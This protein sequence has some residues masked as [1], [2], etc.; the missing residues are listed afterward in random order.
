ML[1]KIYIIVEKDF[2]GHRVVQ[3]YEQ[4][5]SSVSDGDLVYEVR[6]A[7]KVVKQEVKLQEISQ[8]DLN[9]EDHNYK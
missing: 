8:K 4:V 6:E 2:T 9:L 5:I 3:S 7:F 1:E